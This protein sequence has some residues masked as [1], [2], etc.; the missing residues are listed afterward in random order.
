MKFGCEPTE[1][2]VVRGTLS[3]SQPTPVHFLQSTPKSGGF[4]VSPGV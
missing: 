2:V 1:R 4:V 3:G